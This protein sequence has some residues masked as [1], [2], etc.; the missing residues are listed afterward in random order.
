MSSFRKFHEKRRKNREEARKNAALVKQR[1][2]KEGTPVFQK[3]GIETAVI[4]GSLANK[5]YKKASDIDIFV[6]YLSNE[7]YYDFKRE[8]EDAVETPIDLYTDKD[9]TLFVEKIITR[10]EVIYE[11]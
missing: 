2:L 11:I 6:R 8:L 10:G 3:Y 9:D 4:F 5:R 1:L 7:K